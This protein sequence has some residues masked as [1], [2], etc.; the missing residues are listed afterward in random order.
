MPARELLEGAASRT[1]EY[2]LAHC[3]GYRVCSPTGPIGYV[4]AAE[5]DDEGR[6]ERLL[7]RIGERF[8]HVVPIPAGLVQSVDAVHEQIVVGPS[9]RA[10]ADAFDRQLRFPTLAE[11]RAPRPGCRDGAG[12]GAVRSPARPARSVLR[13][14]RSRREHQ[15]ERAEDDGERSDHVRVRHDCPERVHRSSFR[16]TPDWRGDAL[17]TSGRSRIRTP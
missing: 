17:P 11:W 12:G 5:P 16:W 13:P 9:A 1:P 6:L 4:E 2:T 3:E 15:D 10:E 7:V 8:S 14:P